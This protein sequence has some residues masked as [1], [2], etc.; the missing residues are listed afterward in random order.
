MTTGED[1]QKVPDAV[2][3]GKG[4]IFLHRW[5][6]VKKLNAVNKTYRMKYPSGCYFMAGGDMGY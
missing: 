5:T 1:D 6:L 2:S 3:S 4:D